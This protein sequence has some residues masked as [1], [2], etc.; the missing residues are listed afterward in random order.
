MLQ[1]STDAKHFRKYAMPCAIYGQRSHNTGGP[2]E[3]ISV[4][5]LILATK[6]HTVTA[7]EY[8]GVEMGLSGNN[9]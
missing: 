8:L 4:E 3:C 6:V 1:E 2:D 5:D 9:Q 7:M